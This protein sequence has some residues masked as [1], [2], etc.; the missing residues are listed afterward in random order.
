MT[1]DIV[2]THENGRW[3]AR[4]EGLDLEHEDLGALD[5]LIEA[6]LASAESVAV[7][8]DAATLPVWTRQYHAHYFDYRLHPAAERPEPLEAAEAA[9]AAN[10]TER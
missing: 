7:R 6:Q 2:L 4:G 1:P 5:A 8:F 3:R 9:E 10:G